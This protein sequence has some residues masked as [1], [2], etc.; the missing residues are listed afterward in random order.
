[1]KKRDLFDTD[2]DCWPI[3]QYSVIKTPYIEIHYE[4]KSGNCHYFKKQIIFMW[5]FDIGDTVTDV[6]ISFEIQIGRKAMILERSLSQFSSVLSQRYKEIRAKVVCC[7][8]KGQSLFW[9]N[10]L[11]CQCIIL[12]NHISEMKL[13]E[14][15]WLVVWPCAVTCRTTSRGTPRPGKAMSGRFLWLLSA[16]DI[17]LAMSVMC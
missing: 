8:M 3:E 4:P 11:L 16:P 2:S 13:L 12:L 15:V 14:P 9:W 17:G 1:M 6:Y 10:Q 7:G 5:Q